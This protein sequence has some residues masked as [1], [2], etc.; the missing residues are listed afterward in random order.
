MG[1]LQRGRELYFRLIFKNYLCN[2]KTFVKTK[3]NKFLF[4]NFI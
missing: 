4:L 3:N 1:Y 2:N